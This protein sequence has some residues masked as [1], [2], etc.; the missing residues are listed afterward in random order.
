[1]N[2]THLVFSP[3]TTGN[4]YGIYD[5]SGGLPEF[6][7][8]YNSKSNINENQ[9]FAWQNR[10]S[11]KYATAYSNTSYTNTGNIIYQVGKFGDATKEV[12]TTNTLNNNYLNWFNDNYGFLYYNYPYIKRGDQYNSS[13]S[14][15]FYIFHSSGAGAECT[16]RIVLAMDYIN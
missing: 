6:I 15:I 13:Y 10:I 5:L 11:D 8:A 16:S 3:S 4:V 9:S 14:G 12:Y 1:M 7:A 2:L